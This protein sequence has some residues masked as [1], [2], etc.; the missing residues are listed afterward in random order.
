VS[1][2]SWLFTLALVCVPSLAAAQP[3]PPPEPES[4]R[5]GL[6]GGG[7]LYVGEISCEGSNCDGVR[8][9]GGFSAHV[10][11]NFSEKLGLIGDFWVMQNREDDV[12]IT[13]LN[14][15]I[16]LRYWLVPVF[17]IQGGIGSGNARFRYDG[18]I[19]IEGESESIPTGMLAVGL[20][21]VNSKRWA[22]D[23]SLRI[24]Q[25]SET[26]GEDTTGR[27]TGLGVGMTWF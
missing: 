11:Y 10:G 8:E 27:M 13:F 19:D 1:T 24:A 6:F 12:T 5:V 15:S 18:L 2:R 20:E 16:G 17:W 14:G 23:V 4:P 25:G 7:A 22:L 21:L 26:E 9:A 3:P